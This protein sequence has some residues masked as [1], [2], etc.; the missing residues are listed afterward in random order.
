MHTYFL[1][2]NM[3]LLVNFDEGLAQM[4]RNN[5]ETMIPVFE[6]AAKKVYHN[7]YHAIAEAESHTGKVPDW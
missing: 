4:V 3:I 7:N 6:S 1:N 5:P 2:I